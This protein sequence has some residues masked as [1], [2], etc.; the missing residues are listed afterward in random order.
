LDSKT[1]DQLIDLFERLNQE[2]G[3]TFLFSS[4]DMR[5]V[6]RARRRMTIQDGAI[7]SDEGGS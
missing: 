7:I 1:A 2:R 5:L 4:H 6:K 3:V